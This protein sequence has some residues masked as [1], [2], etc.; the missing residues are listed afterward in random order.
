MINKLDVNA[1]CTAYKDKQNNHPLNDGVYIELF[2]IKNGIRYN[3]KTIELKD[4][5]NILTNN[6]LDGI[7]KL[8]R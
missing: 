1:E 3:V 8:W 6:L 5:A 7:E 2:A 4:M